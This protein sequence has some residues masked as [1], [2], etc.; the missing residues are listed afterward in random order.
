MRIIESSKSP[1]NSVMTKKLFI[2]WIVTIIP[3][4]IFLTLYSTNPSSPLLLSL[5]EMTKGLKVLHSANNPLLST[6]MSAWC[7]T[8]PLWGVIVFLVSFSHIEIRGGRSPGH[9]VKGVLLFSV[10]YFP[11]MIILLLN[12]AEM[13]GSGRLYKLMSQSDYL[14]TT[15]FI[16]IYTF[17]YVATTY[18]LVMLFAAFKSFKNKRIIP[19]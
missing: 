6:I 14:L 13:T 16:A 12:S 17:C 7:K 4:I 15:L 18:Y 10:L 19:M 9:I 8:A 5:S 1:N 11:I 2:I 3:F